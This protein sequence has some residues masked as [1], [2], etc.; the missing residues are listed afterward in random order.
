MG[1][2]VGWVLGQTIKMAEMAHRTK[3][4][5]GCNHWGHL[6]E[7]KE[8]VKTKTLTSFYWLQRLYC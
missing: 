7:Q 2:A 3:A 6:V 1:L 4:K 8:K 5:H